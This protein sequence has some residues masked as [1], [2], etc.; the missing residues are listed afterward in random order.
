[1]KLSLTFLALAVATVQAD[2]T[3]K[4]NLAL[5]ESAQE[6]DL[7]TFTYIGIGSEMT[8]SNMKS[9]VTAGECEGDAYALNA[10]GEVVGDLVSPVGDMTMTFADSTTDTGVATVTVDMNTKTASGTPLWT[11]EGDDGGGTLSYCVRY[12]LFAGDNE[13]NFSETVVT[14]TITMVGGFEVPSFAVAEKDRTESS[15]EQAYTVDAAL[16]VGT[17]GTGAGNAFL[18]GSLIC[19]LVTPS[20]TDVEITEITDFTWTNNNPLGATTQVALPNTDGLTSYDTGTDTFSTIL[21]AQFYE[22]G[23]PV[24]GAGT[25]SLGFTTGRRL[26]ASGRVLQEVDA[27]QEFDIVADIVKSDDAPTA[28]QTAGGATASFVVTIV[29]LVGAVL[30]A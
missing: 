18:Q 14:L 2:L 6:G 20:S 27:V 28:L 19:V 4:W 10:G 15:Q 29:G 17:E 16:C 24:N 25:A 1:M 8:L 12:G 3:T 23:I 13:V 7:Y 5:G 26:G 11:A 21:Y 9:S 22:S 30:L